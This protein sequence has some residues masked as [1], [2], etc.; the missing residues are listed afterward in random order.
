M[1]FENMGI[2]YL[3]PVDGHNIQALSARC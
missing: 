3:G 2:T 1:L